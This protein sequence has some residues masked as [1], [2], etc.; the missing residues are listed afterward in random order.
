MPSSHKGRA[1]NSFL[2]WKAGVGEGRRRIP[3]G[4]GTSF[5]AWSANKS[6]AC[7]EGEPGRPTNVY[8]S[9]GGRGGGGD[10]HSRFQDGR[11]RQVGRALHAVLWTSGFCPEGHR[12]MFK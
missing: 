5:K 8:E 9:V 2:E 3:G 1:F 12:R 4:F 6:E 7:E 10:Q 11:G